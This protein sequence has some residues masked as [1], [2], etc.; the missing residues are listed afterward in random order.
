MEGR[1]ILG[2]NESGLSFH[3]VNY[4]QKRQSGSF[5]NLV[6]LAQEENGG[7]SGGKLTERPNFLTT[8]NLRTEER[9]IGASPGKGQ[10]MYSTIINIDD[11]SRESG[12][13][14]STR[15][16]LCIVIASICF[17]ISALLVKKLEK[18][19][20]SV[21]ELMFYRSLSTMLILFVIY[22]FS[23]RNDPSD[24]EIPS[25]GK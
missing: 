22:K 24:N 12:Q 14:S 6:E 20:L 8:P 3:V 21:L 13:S 9:D 1:G 10:D 5:V 25:Y 23:S 4:N 2:R 11:N 15:G 19:T 7:G 18:D 16:F 17:S